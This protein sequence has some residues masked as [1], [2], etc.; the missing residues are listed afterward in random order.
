MGKSKEWKWG[1]VSAE[2]EFV[3][4]PAYDGASDFSE[5]LAAVNIDWARGYIDHKGDFV[6]KPVFGAAG[7][8]KDGIAI[9][10]V[11]GVM[12]C[13]DR[14][15]NFRDDAVGVRE[16]VQEIESGYNPKYELHDGLVRFVE[17]Q[18][19]GYK[20]KDGNVVIEPKFFETYDFSEGLAAV[21]KGK[22]G[23]WGYI[24]T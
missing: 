21:K 8:F 14:E 15:G 19:F 18:K 13:I 22:T 4:A 23:L 7:D 24:D 10:R 3:I 17:N 12:R 20:D 9:V 1:Y 5:G 6:V 16:P 2:G 11:D